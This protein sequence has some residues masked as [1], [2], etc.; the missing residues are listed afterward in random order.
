VRVYVDGGNVIR[1]FFAANLIADVTLSIIPIVL[2]DGIRLFT[3]GEHE[4]RL[5]LEGHRAWPSGLVQMRY[6][7]HASLD[8]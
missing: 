7:V 2:G 8:A 4:H 6:R 1:Q 3:G 5:A